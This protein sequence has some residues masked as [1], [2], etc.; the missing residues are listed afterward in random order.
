MLHNCGHDLKILE[1]P[2]IA[3]LP[4]MIHAFLTCIARWSIIECEQLSSGNRLCAIANRRVFALNILHLMAT[5]THQPLPLLQR[6]LGPEPERP[7]RIEIG[8]SNT[9]SFGREAE[10]TE[11]PRVY[12]FLAEARVISTFRPLAHSLIEAI[13]L[14]SGHLL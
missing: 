1:T 8:A 11:R 10:A 5:N 6:H 14:V 13:D 4:L 7:G 12:V 3:Y 9:G 2:S